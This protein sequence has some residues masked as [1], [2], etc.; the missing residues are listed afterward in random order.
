[1]FHNLIHSG[2]H[3][4][5]VST[6]MSMYKK[7]SARINANKDL[8][9][10]FKCFIGTHQSCMLSPLLFVIYLNMYIDVNYENESQGVYLDKYFCILFMLLYADDSTVF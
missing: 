3:G 5:L 10:L 9:K 4:T 1:M 8:T 7:L 6:L 2:T